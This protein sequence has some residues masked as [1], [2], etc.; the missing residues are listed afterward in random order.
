MTS[1]TSALPRA[2]VAAALTVCL[3]L[4]APAPARAGAYRAAVCNPSLGAGHA[5]AAFA[6]SSPRYEPDASCNSGGSGLVVSHEAGPTQPGGWGA[7]ALRAPRGTFISRVGVSSRGRAGGG[8]VPE[9]LAR[10]IAG[11]LARFA[12][13]GFRT[14]RFGWSGSPAKA[15]SARLRCRLASGCPH[16]RRAAIRVRRATLRLV[17]RTAP[18]LKAAGA[19]FGTGSRRGLQS[20]DLSGSDIGGGIR[21][22]LIQVNDQPVAAHTVR[23]R[24]IGTTAIRLQ[25]CPNAARA[26]FA[27]ATASA[28]FHQGVNR[29]S[30]CAAD[31][32]A[33]TAAN[34]TCAQRR[35]RIDNLCP[36]S[37]VPGARLQAHFANAGRRLTI[38]RGH[39]AAVTGR[40]VSSTGQG[41][42]GASVCVATRVRM[43]GAV[44]QVV[45]TPTTG[46]DGRFR[47]RIPSGPGREVRV[48]HWPTASAAIERYLDLRVR[49]RPSLRISPRHPI[50]NGNRARFEVTLPPPAHRGRRVRIQVRAGG[51]WLTLRS[52]RTSSR[53]VYRTRYRFH[54][55]TG[56][57]TYRFRA[58]VPKQSGYPYTAGRSRVKRVTVVG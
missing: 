39:Q 24:L 22:L 45:A 11:P 34:R 27:A 16:G 2:A 18:T 41:V 47:A 33:T 6:R 57:R 7:W 49:P 46:S 36:I 35:V 43:S 58:T 23:C 19:L 37:N 3:A 40:L 9:L 28:P 15:F 31:F 54:A 52:G 5:D 26:S 13:P 20:V 56:R 17:D 1:P 14:K 44:E 51:R 21:R 42:S 10:P 53:G 32:A 50:H 30:V 55:T 12:N 8:N 29:V 38:G 25:P 48:A 4:A